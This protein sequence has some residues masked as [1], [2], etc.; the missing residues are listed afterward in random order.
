MRFSE[1]LGKVLRAR[2]RELGRSQADVAGA[3]G[4][5]QAWLSGI[6]NGKREPRLDDLEELLRELKLVVTV[7]RWNDA[8]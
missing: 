3:L 5:T 2:R 1:K 7:A 4:H 8:R 6:E